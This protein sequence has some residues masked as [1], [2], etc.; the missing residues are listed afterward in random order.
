MT[1]KLR[2]LPLPTP[3]WRNLKTEYHFSGL[4]YCP[5]K[6]T[7]KMELFEESESASFAF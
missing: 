2:Q 4:A 1:G 7:M 5:H 3:P 6:S